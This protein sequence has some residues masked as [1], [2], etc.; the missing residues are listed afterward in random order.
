MSVCYNVS[1]QPVAYS[2]SILRTRHFPC[3][4]MAPIEPDLHNSNLRPLLLFGSYFVSTFSLLYLILHRVLYQASTSLPPSQATRFRENQRQKHVRIFAG[5][6][7]ISLAVACYYI[8]NFLTVSY[9]VWAH[10]RGEALPLNL[11]GRGGLLGSDDPVD[12]QLGRWLK[13]TSLL[14]EWWEIAI[15][16]SRRFWW[17]QQ[18]VLGTAAWSTFAAIEGTVYFTRRERNSSY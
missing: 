5:L 12:L 13:D 9:R 4:T 6:S 2:P 8:F 15:E 3:A 17:T 16:R 10:E 11:W 14:M 1:A 18:L 7:V